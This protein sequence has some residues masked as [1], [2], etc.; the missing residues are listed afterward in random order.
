[1]AIYIRVQP[2]PDTVLTPTPREGHHLP[3]GR[4]KVRRRSSHTETTLS[5]W[6]LGRTCAIAHSDDEMV[7]GHEMRRGILFERWL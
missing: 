3:F 4:I 1:M 6:G 7:G 2:V 5:R